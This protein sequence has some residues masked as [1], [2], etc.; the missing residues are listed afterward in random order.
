MEKFISKIARR[1]YQNKKDQLEQLIVVMPSKRAGTF[2]KKALAE[3][4]DSPL[5]MPK[6][7]AIEEWLEEL[8][9]LSILGKTHLIF[10]MYI[11]YQNVF[12]KEE[13]DSFEDFLRWGPTLLK[14]FND[15]DAYSN[16][17]EEVF[18]YIHQAKKIES[19]S[20]SGGGPSSLVQN[21]LR[22]WELMGLLFVD[23]KAR[24]KNQNT[25]LIPTDQA[26][27]TLN[28]VAAGLLDAWIWVYKFTSLM[29]SV[30]VENKLG[31]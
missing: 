3:N 17:P 22:F 1:L 30:L 5:W 6:I 7:Y 12:P 31:L 11:S 23:F 28:A 20:P 21:Y 27:K 15:I 16:K 18:N 26:I 13:Q 2:F 14:D 29:K 4:S 8:S 9:G 19:W 10:E 25:C 24:L